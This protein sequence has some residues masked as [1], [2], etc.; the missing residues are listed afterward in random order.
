MGSKLKS[1]LPIL[2]PILNTKLQ[3]SCAKPEF[4]GFFYLNMPMTIG[5][6]I[7]KEKNHVKESIENYHCD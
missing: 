6:H 3:V 5:E 7:T 4:F 2:M 1:L